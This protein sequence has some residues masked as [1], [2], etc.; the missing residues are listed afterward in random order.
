MRVHVAGAAGYAA[1]EAIRF[2]ERHPAIELGALESTSHAGELIGAHFSSLRRSARRF[3]ATGAVDAAAAGGDVVILAGASGSALERAPALLQAGVRVIDLSQDF[4]SD[5]RAVYGFTERY[6]DAIATA[7]LVANPG[8]YPTATLL[9][10]LPLATVAVPA[11]IVVDAKSGITGA[12]RTPSADKLF[13]EVCGDV[14]AYGLAGHRHQSEIERQLASVGWNAPLLFTPHVVPIARGMLV[15]A[16]AI[17]DRPVSGDAV[18]A[19]YARAYAGSPF[20]RLL[21]DGCAPSVTSVA[22]T[23]DAEL[24]VSVHGCAV[25]ALCAIDN[26]GKGAAGQAVQ[27]L[28]V[29]TGLPQECGLDAGV[30]VA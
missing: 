25:R 28:N 3:A 17:F 7:Q 15:N 5:P 22:G 20:V 14:R 30:V 23:N 2:L 6:R 24:Q 26:L 12:G 21:S 16:Y 29:M 4:R 10:L 27:N 13:A 1:A 11:Q 8:C 9:A 18:H 19:A